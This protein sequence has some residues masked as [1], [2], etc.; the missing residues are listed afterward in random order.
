MTYFHAEPLTSTA[1]GAVDEEPRRTDRELFVEVY[2]KYWN[3]LYEIAYRRLPD[4]ESAEEVVQEIFTD[5]WEKRDI[6]NIR[7]V[8]N[9]LTRAIK[10]AIID[11]IRRLSA[12]KRFLDYHKTFLEIQTVDQS[13][14]DYQE[15]PEILQD[16]MGGLSDTTRKIFWFNHIMDWKKDRIAD[17]FQ[18]SEKAIEYHL[19]KSLK[20]VKIY[21]KNISF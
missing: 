9:Y 11:H 20:T 18:L 13:V 19:T 1:P 12:R 16:S 3:K 4:K 2:E 15:L 8:E 21:L 7:N 17:Y 14:L 10:F 5:L 6:R